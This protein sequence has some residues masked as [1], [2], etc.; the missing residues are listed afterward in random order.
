ME[1]VER[2]IDIFNLPPKYRT[3]LQLFYYEGYSVKEIAK[4]MK[5]SEKTVTSQLCRARKRLKI[6][7]EV[8]EYA[9][10]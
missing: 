9:G 10:A 6:E 2:L 3:V 7:M 5:I 1:D 8:G 4:I